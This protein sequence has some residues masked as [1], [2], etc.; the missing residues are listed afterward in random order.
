MTL[1]SVHTTN[2]SKCMKEPPFQRMLCCKI[3]SCIF[4]VIP[5]FEGV[6][7]LEKRTFMDVRSEVRRSRHSYIPSSFLRTQESV[8]PTWA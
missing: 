7:E 6:A 5:A 4:L 8:C 1:G 2:L 3:H